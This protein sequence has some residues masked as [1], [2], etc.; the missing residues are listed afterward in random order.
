MF[1]AAILRISREME[2]AWN[3]GLS[4][5]GMNVDGILAIS[6]L[7]HLVCVRARQIHIFFFPSLFGPVFLVR[8]CKRRRDCENSSILGCAV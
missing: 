5:I 3:E 7:F 1:F 4:P 2:D 8:T 6:I